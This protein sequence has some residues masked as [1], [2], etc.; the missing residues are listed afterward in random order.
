[1]NHRARGKA[2]LVWRASDFNPYDCT[3]FTF[4]GAKT[5]TDNCEEAGAVAAKNLS[6]PFESTTARK[7]GLWP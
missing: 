6:V 1:M 5:G 4:D 2:S 3:G 7:L